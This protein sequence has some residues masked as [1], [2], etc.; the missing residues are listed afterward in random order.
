MISEKD[1][2]DGRNEKEKIKDLLAKQEEEEIR[3][4]KEGMNEW[5]S[6]QNEMKK[7]EGEAFKKNLANK[8]DSDSIEESADLH[9]PD[10]KE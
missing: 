2:S 3:K 8:D 10:K 5:K 9:K 4:I 7:K 1:L 6:K